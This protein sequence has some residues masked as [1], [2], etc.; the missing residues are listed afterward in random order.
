MSPF[1]TAIDK[2]VIH[3]ACGRETSL[4]RAFVL[5]LKNTSHPR[6]MLSCP[7]F[8]MVFGLYF[9]T[10]ASANVV[11]TGCQRTGRDAALPK[12]AAAAAV[13]LPL[14]ILQDR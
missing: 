2:A 12:A 5:E 4:W 6:R 8:R 14:S 10:Y 9:A 3:L 1:I 7:G 13:N 11:D